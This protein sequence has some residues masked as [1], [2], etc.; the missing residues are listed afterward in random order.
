MSRSTGVRLTDVAAE[1]GV[2]VAT[3]SKALNGSGQLRTETRRRVIDAAQKLGLYPDRLTSALPSGRTYTV[4]I[5]STDAYGRFTIPI[6][7]GAEDSLGA[8]EI[9]MLLC[10]SRRD[11]IREQHYLRTLLRRGVDGIIVTGHSSDP[12]ASI[13][14]DLGVPIV[15]ALTCST[16]PD[17]L[18]VVPDDAGGAVRA[19][20]HLV[21]SGRSAIAMVAGPKRHR[22]TEHRVAGCT[23]ALAEAGLEPVSG[24]ALYGEWTEQWGRDAVAVLL[25][26][27]PHLDGVFCANDQIA[28]GVLDGL[29]DAGR[30]VPEEI[31]V[32]GMDNWRV[33]AE[34]ARPPLTTVDLNLTEVG[35]VAASRLVGAV[36]GGRLPSGQIAVDC[37]LVVRQ[38]G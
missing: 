33:L 22:A 5:I 29:R 35:R 27:G 9:S 25:A 24:E 10:E 23:R 31:G 8:G 37:S 12:R 7:I 34:A 6:L 30:R 18:S 26:R 32:V 4:G 15:Y 3:V 2:S 14:R 17:D 19:V 1:A 11:Q 38:S 21:A 20:R 28:R 13:G 16:D 36:T